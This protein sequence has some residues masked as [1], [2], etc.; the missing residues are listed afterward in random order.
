MSGWRDARNVLAVRLDNIGDVV[1]LSPALRAVKSSRADMRITLLA[2]PAGATAARL[3]PWI[4]DVIVWRAV[5]QD[6]GGR[7]PLDPDRERAL[8]AAIR[9][10]RF[11]AALIFTSFSQTP[12]VPGYACYLAGVPLRAGEGKEFGG[13]VLTTELRDAPDEMHQAERNVRLVEAVGYRV[14]DRRLTI[15]IDDGERRSARELVG[16]RPF[17]LVHPGASAAARRWPASRYASVVRGLTERDTRVVVVGAELERQDVLEAAGDRADALVGRTT[18]GELAALVELASAVI[19][20]NSLPLH[21]ADAVGTPVVALYSGTDLESQWAPRFAPA[22]LLR[23]ETPCHPC[24]GFTCDIGLAC[25]AVD[26][27]EVIEAAFALRRDAAA[28]VVA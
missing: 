26:P 9:E 19:C 2:S 3:L 22:R 23:R 28:E 18:L 11:D 6:V 7:M 12:H 1:L 16:A 4:D 24:Y 14:S 10:R 15:R 21:L 5:W 8:I 20:G 13:S 27:A 17:V 25:L